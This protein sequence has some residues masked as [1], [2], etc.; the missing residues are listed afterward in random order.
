MQL[1]RIAGWLLVG[2]AIAACGGAMAL[3]FEIGLNSDNQ[4]YLQQTQRWLQGRPLYT[5]LVMP[6]PPMIF[7]LYAPVVGASL[8]SGLP[9]SLG[10]DVWTSCLLAVSLLLCH[11]IL[12]C[13]PAP[14]DPLI[15]WLILSLIAA[16]LVILPL[17]DNVFGD[18]DHL[19]ALLFSPYLLLLSPYGVTAG[20]GRRSRVL[21]SVCAAIGLGIKPYLLAIWGMQQ[22][23]WMLRERSLLRV[24]RRFETQLVGAAFG[25]YALAIWLATPEYLRTVAPMA[26]ATYPAIS[27]PF[28]HRLATIVR[29]WTMILALPLAGS[30]SLLRRASRPAL[31]NITYFLCASVGASISGFAGGWHYAYY[32][33]Y[34]LA[35]AFAVS[36]IAGL[37][38]AVRDF[39][40]AS[41][42]LAG[43]FLLGATFLSVMPVATQLFE[44]ARE[45]GAIDAEQQRRT[46]WPRGRQRPPAEIG[47]FFDKHLGVV[48][49]PR[50]LLLGNGLWDSRLVD[51]DPARTSVARFYALWPLPALVAAGS[52]PEHAARMAWIR[53]YLY[54]GLT[55]DLR[56]NR[57]DVVFV[58]RS[59]WM[60]G[61]PRSFDVLGFCLRHPPFAEAWRDYVLVEQIDVCAQWPNLCA[62][63]VFYRKDL[64]R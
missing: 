38:A 34:L 60:W 15:R 48:A 53:R 9:F 2:L 39:W 23:Y 27:P 52:E 62:F 43:G 11:H 28:S 17:R 61:L 24:P 57:P 14:H 13:R 41:K 45:R 59:V 16:G 42:T 29:A 36:V 22:A 54:R 58:E 8:A 30:A 19:F 40:P 5:S 20:L 47:R 63:D 31:R 55:E 4:L 56:D 7:A 33:L 12:A 50:F 21:I 32:P 3:H 1:P 10:F 37:L 44:P 26:W 6:S 25:A 35:F 64:I 46:G 18:R 51:F 49:Q